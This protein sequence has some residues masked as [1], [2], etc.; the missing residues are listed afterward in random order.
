MY[1]KKPSLLGMLGKA[2]LEGLLHGVARGEEE[3]RTKEAA[4]RAERERQAQAE[5]EAKRTKLPPFLNDALSATDSSPDNSVVDE[6]E[7]FRKYG[8]T[9]EEIAR[10]ALDPEFRNQLNS[11]RAESDAISR[12]AEARRRHHEAFAL[13]RLKASYQT[14]QPGRKPC[15]E[16]EG[17][18]SYNSTRYGYVQCPRCYGKGTLAVD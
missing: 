15:H 5:E 9:L 10:A 12:E 14:V 7:V 4:E 8:L 18:G 11:Q 2:A 6:D 3:K 1:Q 17:N 13:Q 16:C